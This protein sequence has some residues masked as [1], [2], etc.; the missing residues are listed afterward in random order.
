MRHFRPGF[1]L[2]ELLIALAVLGILAAIC[3]PSYQQYVLRTYRA[4][5]T[6]QLLQL[7]AAQEQHLADYGVYNDDITVLGGTALSPSERYEF[8]V[9]LSEQQLA[10]EITAA[11]TGLQRADTDCLL[12]SV[13]QYVQRNRQNPAAEG[14]WD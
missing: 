2:I 11:A 14:C 6:A 7:A 4:E 5:A 13:N 3:Y 1:S 8:Q 12:F 9:Q 10:F